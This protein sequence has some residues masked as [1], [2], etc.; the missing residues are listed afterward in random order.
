MQI[1][2]KMQPKNCEHFVNICRISPYIGRFRLS[3]YHP[4]FG[5]QAN[6]QTNIQPGVVEAPFVMAG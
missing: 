5:N 1:H 6:F 4:D 2:P 3:L